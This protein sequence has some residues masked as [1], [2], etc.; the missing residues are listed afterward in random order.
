MRPLLTVTL[1]ALTVGTA[2]CAERGEPSP[3]PKA[4]APAG[5]T[6]TLTATTVDDYKPVAAAVTTRNMAEARARIGGTLSALLVREGDYVQKGQLIAQVSD[7]RLD[8]ETTGYEAQAA[9]AAAEAARADADLARV[10]TLYDKGFYAKARLDQATAAA[11]AARGQV[12][13]ARARR[14]ASAELGA[15]GAILAPSSGRILKAPAPAGSVVA[16]GQSVATLTSG[17]PL[18][19]LDM[20]ESQARAL[21]VGDRLPVASDDIPGLA[22]YGTVIQVYPA[23]TAGQVTADLAVEGLRADLVGQRVGV[24]VKIGERQAL[25]VPARYVARRFGLDFVRLVAPDGSVSDIAVQT[26][27]AA[28]TGMVE[29]LSGA[30]PGDRLAPAQAEV[31][32]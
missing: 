2:A 24:K 28:T 18:L 7:Q 3:A 11:K 9:A 32:R 30:R 10:Q 20:P 26:T 22:A 27:P 6:L 8:L 19:R 21:K 29:I 12:D 13:A 1:L 25:V 23:V 4:V 15:Q 5:D 31:A 14:A 17:Q 16:A